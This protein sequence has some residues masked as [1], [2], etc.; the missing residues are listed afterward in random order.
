MLIQQPKLGTNIVITWIGVT[1][2]N[3]TNQVVTVKWNAETNAHYQLQATTVL[4]NAASLVWSNVGPTVI[5]PANE[6]R[7]TNAWTFQRYYRVIAPYVAP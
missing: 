6:Q 2:L 7:E 1:N 3:L 5:G 4:S